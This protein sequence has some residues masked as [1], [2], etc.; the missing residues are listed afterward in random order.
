MGFELAESA[1]RLEA[2]QSPRQVALVRVQQRY[3]DGWDRRGHG[4][5][6]AYMVARLVPRHLFG[7]CELE[8]TFYV[9]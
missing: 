8:L 9:Q 3:V 7:L 2:A 6:V 4:G 1:R 5:E